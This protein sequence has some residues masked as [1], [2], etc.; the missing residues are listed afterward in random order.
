MPACMRPC[1]RRYRRINNPAIHFLS[2]WTHGR[3]TPKNKLRYPVSQL[4][5]LRTKKAAV[6]KNFFWMCSLHPCVHASLLACFHALMPAIPHASMHRGLS[7]N[8]R[9]KRFMR[10]CCHAPMRPWCHGAMLS[11]IHEAMDSWVVKAKIV[12]CK[13]SPFD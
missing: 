12:C 10:T 2:P 13:K 6:E 7:A 9:M 11:C 4:W 5:R 8:Y 1:M 3:M